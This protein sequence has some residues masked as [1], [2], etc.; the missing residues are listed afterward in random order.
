MLDTS[1]FNKFLQLAQQINYIKRISL[2]KTY[3]N[4]KTDDEQNYIWHLPSAK[5]REFNIMF[6]KY[7]KKSK[8]QI[9][10]KILKDIFISQNIY[11]NLIQFKENII[12]RMIDIF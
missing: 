1:I 2:F 4:Y 12:L 5:T 3:N 9:N 7:K 10:K 11:K 8:V 6:K